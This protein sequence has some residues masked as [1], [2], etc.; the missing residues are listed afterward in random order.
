MLGGEGMLLTTMGMQDARKIVCMSQ[1]S[2]AL[3]MV[4]ARAWDSVIALTMERLELRT[5]S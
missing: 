1:V 5:G 3:E 4:N 2:D